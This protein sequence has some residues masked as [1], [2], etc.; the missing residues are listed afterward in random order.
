MLAVYKRSSLLWKV[1]NYSCK[2]FYDIG[3]RIPNF[4]LMPKFCSPYHMKSRDQV[5]N[6]FCGVRHNKLERLILP[7]ISILVQ[8]F[9]VR[10]RISTQL[11]G[12]PFNACRTI[13]QR[14]KWLPEWNTH[15]ACTIK[16]ITAVIFAISLKGR[17]FANLSHIHPSLLFVC[18]AITRV[19]P[20]G[21][22]NSNGWL[23]ALPQNIIVGWKWPVW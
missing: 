2:K 6:I 4:L 12:L 16:H 23:P 3:P 15:G 9:L 7:N 14:W 5:T 8:H 22:L 1:V 20:L 19:E 11:G 13:S 21:G 18:K 10:I 17:E